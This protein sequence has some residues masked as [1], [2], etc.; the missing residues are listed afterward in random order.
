MKNIVLKVPTA[1]FL[2]LVIWPFIIAALQIVAD[3][4]LLDLK[5]YGILGVISGLVSSIWLFS[6]VDYFQSKS[7]E[8][9]FT[10]V[11]YILL[12]VE[13]VVSLLKSFGVFSSIGMISLVINAFQILVYVAAV[14]YITLLIRK[15]FYERAVWFIV[16]EVLIVVVGITTLTPEIKRNEQELLAS[17]LNDM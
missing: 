16:L 10:N 8:F 5:Y 1:I 17:D 9:K 6:I 15:V 13:L 4:E 12:G 11:I 3:R 2:V 14:V 7:P